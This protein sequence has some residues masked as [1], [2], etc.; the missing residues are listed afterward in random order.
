LTSW[1]ATNN[2]PAFFW[3]Y[4]TYPIIGFEAKFLDH[5]H[6]RL[7]IPGKPQQQ[8]PKYLSKV[9]GSEPRIEGVGGK[10]SWEVDTYAIPI[11][12]NTTIM[13]WL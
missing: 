12:T 4:L 2:K 1:I 6:R 8:T 7:S 9:S 11:G 13:V 10:G 5:F 3:L